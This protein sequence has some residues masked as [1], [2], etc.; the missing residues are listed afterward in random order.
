MSRGVLLVV[1]LIAGCGG[2]SPKQIASC[3]A[4]SGRMRE[5][6]S[7]LVDRYRWD[8]QAAAETTWHAMRNDRVV[9]EQRDDCLAHAVSISPAPLRNCLEDQ[10][11]LP[12]PADSIAQTW[13]AIARSVKG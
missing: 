3:R 9:V 11:W 12:Q 8:G 5:V 13:A 7:C 10:G 4:I 1:L 2:Q 6:A